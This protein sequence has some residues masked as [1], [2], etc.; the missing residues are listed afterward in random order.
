MKDWGEM[1]GR[2]SLDAMR[3]SQNRLRSDWERVWARAHNGPG[4][5]LL[6]VIISL[7][8]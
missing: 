5:G 7:S 4:Y 1:M 6:E 3:S 2:P 8:L